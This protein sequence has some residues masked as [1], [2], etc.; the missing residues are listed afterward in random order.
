MKFLV[1]I[2]VFYSLFLFSCD[3][4]SDVG[5]NEILSDKQN[6]ISVKYIEIPLDASNI[7]YDSIRTDDGE[8]YFG[9]YNDPIFGETKAIAYTQFSSTISEVPQPNVTT[10]NYYLDLPNDSSNLDSAILYLKLFSY[11]GTD[12]VDE[13]EIT[14]T[15]IEDTLFT[16]GLYLSNRYTPI[17]EGNKGLLG[18]TRFLGRPNLDTTISI[19]IKKSYAEFLLNRIADGASENELIN[20]LRGWA[21]VP[22]DNNTLIVGFNLIDDESKIVLY[23]NNPYPLND[24]PIKDSLQYVF[25]FTSP[26]IKHYSY[27]ETKR[28]NSKL[29]DIDALGENQIFNTNDDLIYWQS[30]TGIYPFIDLK[31]FYTFIDT[32]GSIVFNKVQLT[33]G[34]IENNDFPYIKAPGRAIYYFAD[35]NNKINSTG[36]YTNPTNN[37]ILKDNAYYGENTENAEYVYDS[38]FTKSYIG[39]ST[40]FF[41]EVIQGNIS[42]KKLVVFPDNVSS[43]NQAVINKNSFILRVFYTDYKE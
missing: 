39:S 13:Q 19:P 40:I 17:S 6:K 20:Q 11:H 29:S 24:S 21:L 3:E 15:Q 38:L 28:E 35:S 25:R 27:I 22:G 18:F 23:Y 33:M 8:L 1:R 14:L 32:V 7:H 16:T 42:P 10:E 5:I 41:Q 30:S 43:F 26:L 9:R 12:F 37:A 2:I 31:N 36:I 4:I 34:P